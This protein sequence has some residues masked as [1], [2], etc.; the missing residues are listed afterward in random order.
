MGGVLLMHP[1]GF[2]VPLA[3]KRNSAIY[4]LIILDGG[5]NKNILDTLD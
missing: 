1:F 2:N 4:L 5:E 3:S